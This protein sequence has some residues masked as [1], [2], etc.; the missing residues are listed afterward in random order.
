M[1]GTVAGSCRRSRRG[2]LQSCAFHREAYTASQPGAEHGA[3]TSLSCWMPP[4]APG[5]RNRVGSCQ[6][7]DCWGPH[8]RGGAGSP[9]MRRRERWQR[10]LTREDTSATLL[11]P[12]QGLRLLC[13]L[14]G[15]LIL[16]PHRFLLIMKDYNT[17]NNTERFISFVLLCIVSDYALFQSFSFCLF[18]DF[19]HLI[20]FHLAQCF[21]LLCWKLCLLFLSSMLS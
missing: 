9:F 1:Q 18:L 11:P 12:P 5:R 2:H 8:H 21:L 6:R 14:T 7:S 4:E 19:P 20:H 15:L 10:L 16:L 3:P 17:G 13:W